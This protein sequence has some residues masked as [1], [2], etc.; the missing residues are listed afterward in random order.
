MR[1]SLFRQ[2][3]E[4]QNARCDYYTHSFQVLYSINYG[5]SLSWVETTHANPV[6]PLVLLGR[7]CDER[8]HVVIGVFTLH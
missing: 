3:C 6:V 4:A 5:E 7:M 2:R 8:M 1:Q